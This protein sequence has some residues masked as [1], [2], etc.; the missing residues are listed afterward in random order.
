[1]SKKMAVYKCN[2]CGTVVEGMNDTDIDVV[3]C[4]KT[5]VMLKENTTDAA[6]EKHVPV[7]EKADGGVK[8]V[9][10]STP[11]PMGDDHW[12]EWIEIIAGKTIYRQFLDPAETP[13]AFFPINEKDIIVRAYC[14]LHGLWK[15]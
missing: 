14:N 2:K 15:S 6:Q 12:I 11:H 1:M 5:M 8:V 3:C 10:G 7:I 9:V 4:G 13:E